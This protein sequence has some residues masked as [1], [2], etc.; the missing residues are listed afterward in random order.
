MSAEHFS[1]LLP[2]RGDAERV[3][4]AKILQVLNNNGGGT[5]TGT[6][7]SGNG[8]PSSTPTSAALYVQLDS[9]PPGVIWYWN[10]S[11]WA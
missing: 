6:V 9:T 1:S 7:S 5:G 10:G 2:G 11:A 4:E 3:L 8:A